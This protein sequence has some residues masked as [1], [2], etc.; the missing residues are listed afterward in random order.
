MTKLELRL[1]RGLEKNIRENT[2]L[3]C[4]IIP[5]EGFQYTDEILRSLDLFKKLV[6]SGEDDVER[7][8]KSYDSKRF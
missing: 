1:L 4:D 8:R 6:K 5:E 7:R 2:G 3:I